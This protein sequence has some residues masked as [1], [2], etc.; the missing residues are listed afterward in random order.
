MNVLLVCHTP[1]EKYGSFE[2]FLSELSRELVKRGNQAIMIFPRIDDHEVSRQLRDAGAIVE[3]VS[4]VR[5]RSLEF[6]RVVE[7][8]V[9]GYGAQLVHFYFYSHRSLIPFLLKARVKDE[10]RTVFHIS[11]SVSPPYGLRRYI[12][13]TRVVL[14]LADRVIAV[15]D[16]T[17][18][19]V[20]A[21]GVS[22]VEVVYDGVSLSDFSDD[23]SAADLH[24]EFGVSRNHFVITSVGSLIPL[25][26]WDTVIEAVPIILEQVP[27]IIWL[28]IGEGRNF[29]EFRGDYYRALCKELHLEHVIKFAGRVGNV[30]NYLR[31]TDLFVHNS[32]SEGLP[33]V[34]LE[35]MA[36]GL[37]VISTRVGGIPELISHGQN[38]ILIDP[39]SPQELS[40]TVVRL[41]KDPEQLQLLG[42]KALETA[43]EYSVE[44]TVQKV[45]DVYSDLLE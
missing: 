40:T 41:L 1:C 20:S 34:I 23:V 11:A 4:N 9:S 8:F 37:P 13:G 26:G 14:T 5:W 32:Q 35:A 21:Y 24:G 44:E 2:K 27:N 15:S 36:A 19:S 38:G 17:K 6:L 25:K 16:D 10:I 33:L 22:S 28:I 30:E 31:S 7:R 3:L 45:I 43:R 42:S 12:S 18:Q 39:D 29:P